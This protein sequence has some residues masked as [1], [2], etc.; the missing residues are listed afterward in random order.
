MDIIIILHIC[1]HR[2]EIKAPPHVRFRRVLEMNEVLKGKDNWKRSVAGGN[3]CLPNGTSGSKTRC[4]SAAGRV[5][6]IFK[7]ISLIRPARRGGWTVGFIDKQHLY[8][9]V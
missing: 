9:K 4:P 3:I 2:S 1:T 7:T 5:K 8:V 6:F